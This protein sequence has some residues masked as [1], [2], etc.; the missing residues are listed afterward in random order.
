[1]TTITNKQTKANLPIEHLGL[2]V[3]NGQWHLNDNPLSVSLKHS[4]PL[5]G[6]SE[7]VRLV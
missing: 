1:M 2:R 4:C 6:E 7:H 5:H 3:G